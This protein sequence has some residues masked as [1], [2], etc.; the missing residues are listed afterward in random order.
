MTN[1]NVN[2]CK[3]IAC[4]NINNFEYLISY[5]IIP[6]SDKVIGFLGDHYKLVIKYKSKQAEILQLE[7]F[8]KTLPQG[9]TQFSEYVTEI[10]AFKKETLF[11]KHILPKLATSNRQFSPKCILITDTY[12]ILEDLKIF[13][14]ATFTDPFEYDHWKAVLKA[15]TKFHTSSLIYEECAIKNKSEHI[16]YYLCPEAFQEATFNFRNDHKRGMWLRN[17][18]KS[19]VDLLQIYNCNRGKEVSCKLVNFIFNKLAFYLKPSK[20]YR[21]V[22]THSDLWANN[23]L[24]ATKHNNGKKSVMVDYQLIRFGPP[25]FDLLSTLFL[26]TDEHFLNNNF[27]QLLRNYYQAFTLHFNRHAMDVN[28]IISLDNFLKSVEEYQMPAVI[29][30]TFFGTIVFVSNEL[31]GRIVSDK[32]TF[33]EF[34]FFNRSKYLLK[35][36]SENIEFKK[37]MDM[38]LKRLVD[39]VLSTHVKL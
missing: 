21:N 18:T 28:S 10:G 29:E 13:N 8:M 2:T 24:F 1:V 6:Y 9:I 5:K 35:E 22:V 7:Y 4:E 37:K 36:Y 31:S 38:L 14:F 30:A 23:I 26:N 33:E 27:E 11:Y 3:Q 25:A 15:L 34:T 20:K 12:I 39:I 17:C 32:D 19:V 16:I